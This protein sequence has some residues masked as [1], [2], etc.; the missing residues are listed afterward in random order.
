MGF[1]NDEAPA[2]STIVVLVL[3]SHLITS[4]PAHTLMTTGVVD[5]A[6]YCLTLERPGFRLPLN[7][8]R[9]RF[10]TLIENR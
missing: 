7:V 9:C 4:R 5:R 3:S 2:H 1:Q 6:L 8:R 10:D